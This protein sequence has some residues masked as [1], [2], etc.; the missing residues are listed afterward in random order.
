[1]ICKLSNVDFNDILTVVNDA[2]CAYKGKIP[3]DRWKEPYMTPKELQGQ[4]EG[5]VQ[6]YGWK[7][8]NTLLAVMGIQPVG[9]VTLI[10]HSYVLTSHQ[11]RGLGEK[12]LRHLLCK[13]KTSTVYVGTWQAA[14]WAIKFYEKLGFN[15]VSEREKN[16]LLNKHWNI[17]ERQ[18]ETSVVLELKRQAR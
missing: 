4:I 10:R 16:K 5:G 15:L 17:P 11:R 3:P 12:L 1:M 14:T 6:F 7:E 2:A 9:E 8:S 13:V 18:I